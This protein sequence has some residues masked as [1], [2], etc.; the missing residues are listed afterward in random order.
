MNGMLHCEEGDYNTAY[1]YFWEA[2]EQ[3]DSLNDWDRS[4]SCLKYMML[5][6]IFEDLVKASGNYTRRPLHGKFNNRLSRMISVHQNL[7][8][9][10][11]DL[12][13]MEAIALAA[14]KRSIKL[15]DDLIQS[16]EE[17][18][19]NDILI[20]HNLSI[21]REKLLESNLI[22]II[23]PYSCVEISYVA[24]LIEMPMQPVE[25]KLSQ[26]ILDGTLNG[27]LDQGE[28]HLIVCDEKVK[29]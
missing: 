24:L 5:C 19:L 2:F 10:C 18:L 4:L 20:G 1:S 21:L 12:D 8:Y 7:K 27:I 17:I 3:L 13:A 14:S 11:R 23:E 6:R 26:M 28:G 16:Y 15:F 22:R 9:S 25:K 29:D